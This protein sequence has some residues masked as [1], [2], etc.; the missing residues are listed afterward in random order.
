MALVDREAR[1][2]AVRDCAALVCRT[3]RGCA[4]LRTLGLALEG[5]TLDALAASLS[6]DALS[7]CD[8]AAVRTALPHPDCDDL[9]E[10]I[11]DRR[12]ATLDDTL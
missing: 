2:C 5:A 9:V 3:T 7:R 4:S 6:D 8:A 1:G 11:R 10:R 12:R